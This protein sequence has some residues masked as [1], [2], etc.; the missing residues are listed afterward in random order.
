MAIAPFITNVFRRRPPASGLDRIRDRRRRE[1]MPA[2]LRLES[3]EQ[4]AMLAVSYV[5]NAIAGTLDI[6]MTGSDNSA[7]LEF[8]G[9][10]DDDSS[11]VIGRLST[12]SMPD[13]VLLGTIRQVNVVSP[14]AEP[15]NQMSFGI[16]PFSATFAGSSFV[17]EGSGNTAS[18]FFATTVGGVVPAAGLNLTNIDVLSFAQAAEIRLD[19]TFTNPFGD[20]TVQVAYQSAGR[21]VTEVILG[22]NGPLVADNI[23]VESSKAI[24]MFNPI[25]GSNDVVLRSSAPLEINYDI[26]AGKTLVLD[27]DGGILQAVSSTLRAPVLEVVNRANVNNTGNVELSSAK[28]DFN[29]IH[30]QSFT[31]GDIAIRDCN[32]LLIAHTSFLAEPGEFIVHADGLLTIDGPVKSAGFKAYSGTAITST[33]RGSLT[34]GNGGI[35]LTARA[36]ASA[37][38]G[39]IT[40]QGRVDIGTAGTP[41]A[42]INNA[43]RAD[44]EIAIAGGLFA[45]QGGV[46]VVEGRQ[47]IVIASPVQ[48]G[49]SFLAATG[50]AVVVTA[51]DLTLVSSA[52]FVD[53]LDFPGNWTVDTV[54]ATNQVLIDAFGD[55]YIDAEVQAGTRFGNPADF[56][57]TKV[58]PNIA[59]RGNADITIT[60]R[61]GLRTS[62][63]ATDPNDTSNPLV[64]LVAVRGASLFTHE[65]VIDADGGVLVNVEGDALL[66]GP[67][68]ARTDIDV[69]SLFGS[70]DVQGATE[71]TGMVMAGTAK[72]TPTANVTLRAANGA[73]ATSGQGSIS[74]GVVITKTSN[75]A[76]T[77]TLEAQQSIQLGAAIDT[78]GDIAVTST[79]GEIDMSALLRTPSLA[80]AAVGPSI[81]LTAGN[82]IYQSDR[83][84]GRIVTDSLALINTG[85]AGPALATDIDVRGVRNSVGEF[86]ALNLALGGDVL[87]SVEGAMKVGFIKTTGE[88]LADLTSSAGM[89]QTG[90]ILTTNLRASNRDGGAINL[91][92]AGNNVERFAAKNLGAVTYND[93]GKFRVGLQTSVEIVMGV[94]KMM[95]VEVTG[96]QVTL[97]AVEGIRVV[98]GIQASAL[99]M[100]APEVEFVTTNAGDS[101]SVT[102]AGRLRDMILLSN[103]NLDLVSDHIMAFDGEYDV[104]TKVG[105]VPITEIAVQAALPAYTRRMTFDGG[106]VHESV[107][108]GRLG[109]LGRAGVPSGVHLGI[110]SAGSRVT[111]TAIYGFTTGSA[112]VVES[113]NNAV[114]N[115]FIGLRADGTVVPNRLGVNVS[116]VRANSN[117]VGTEMF[118]SL[119]VGVVANVRLLARGQVLAAVR[120]TVSVTIAPPVGGGT[121]ATAVPLVE[122][123][124]PG[125]FALTAIILTSPGS[126]YAIGESPAVTVTGMPGAQAVAF[127]SIQTRANHF[128][129]NTDAA[130]VVQRGG[131]NN[132]IAGNIVGVPGRMPNR[133][134]VRID[135][136]SGNRV[137]TA[138]QVTDDL[139]PT[140]SNLIR[141]NTHYGVEIRNVRGATTVV[142]NN[143]VAGNATADGG[144]TAGI[145]QGAHGIGVLNSMNV[146]IGGA[147]ELASNQVHSQRFGSGVHLS[148]STNVAITGNHIGTEGFH[149]TANAHYPD[150]VPV[151]PDMPSGRGNLPLLGNGRHGIDVFGRS[152]DIQISA[153]RI[154]DNA[155]SGVSIAAGSSGVVLT[156]NEIGAWIHPVTG[157]IHAAGNVA[158][159]VTIMAANG[160][161]VG[162]G[163]VIGYN[164]GSG[165][166]IENAVAAGLQTGNRVSGSDVFRNL[167]HGVH[168]SG[169]SRQ[170]IGG[171]GTDDGNIVKE[172]GRDG[173]RIEANPRIRASAAPAGNLVR[174][175]FVGTSDNQEIDRNWGNRAG[176]AVIDGVE[177]V[178]SNN[179]VMNNRQAGVEIAGGVGNVLGGQSQNDANFVG[180]NFGDGVFVHDQ[181]STQRDVG[182]VGTT[183][184]NGGAGYAASRTNVVF[185]APAAAG[186]VAARGVALITDDGR[187]DGIRL[188][189]AG[190]GYQAGEVVTVTIFDAL[191]TAQATATVTLGTI[192]AVSAVALSHVISGNEIESNTGVGVYIKGDR[193]FETQVG[194]NFD[195]QGGAGLGN[196]I[197]FHSIGVLV[198]AARRTRVQGNRYGDNATPFDIINGGNQIRIPGLPPVSPVVTAPVSTVAG[199][200]L[201]RVDASVSNAGNYH[202]YWVDVYATPYWDMAHDFNGNPSGHQ[203]RQH[204]GR[205]LIT[206][207]GFGRAT[208]G[209]TLSGEVGI[210]DYVSLTL[211][212]ARYEPGTTFLPVHA[213]VWHDVPQPGTTGPT[214]SGSTGTSGRISSPSRGSVSPGRV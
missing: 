210:G 133:T 101:A 105:F 61:G 161:I 83:D 72:V 84:L 109:L 167:G 112:V 20:A 26:T 96:S 4:R 42:V 79:F 29:E 162:S 36:V 140:P 14:V 173:V 6:N 177:N 213:M 64:G 47:G 178:L 94:E 93:A 63:L 46:T 182:V 205:T 184:T 209:F 137:G 23:R 9:F 175:N 169:S 197:K 87:V 40:L 67:T 28:N 134:G 66:L 55:V 48:V 132:L 10:T 56:T 130:V 90:P 22:T 118:G 129:G 172:N 78:P 139:T 110:G 27:G 21:D 52:G 200:R 189:S 142:E 103:A 138:A 190:R 135:G 53:I 12:S 165:V 154:V 188:T 39:D 170:T 85:A 70:I 100:T 18:G 157:N 117:T 80:P 74:A 193:V 141:G 121:A 82:G 57:L 214:D 86:T 201:T 13:T 33:K 50:D 160:N 192:Q 102:F 44:G 25:V 62:A 180:Y 212:S 116:G 98:A 174:G 202:Q 153:N 54:Q 51:A 185:T 114:D 211:T 164:R 136:G 196:S 127:T 19:G 155:F 75:V 5:Y 3:L 123:I 186:G 1:R 122:E 68:R 143:L 128:A 7:H 206:T 176:I 45:P 43:I 113:S 147:S 191:A 97:S 49:A 89:T 17:I 181:A 120:P 144:G 108:S 91:S 58:I 106:R 69:L 34:I 152:R 194:Q 151:W 31:T 38:P 11:R 77:V 156:R 60:P 126:G 131:S 59:I 107:A 208:I 150:S 24:T 30:F 207:D 198:D 35:D 124:E 204:L 32:D 16:W 65:G 166:H 125:V 88:A 2:A 111:G 168:I 199:L 37:A 119:P 158:D 71:S 95:G 195:A 149:L 163:N 115:M 81:A 41:P 73:I 146:L 179:V 171:F 104:K 99:R 145:G 8:A 183:I 76:G 187:V 148:G 159:G 203:M 92:N 15:G